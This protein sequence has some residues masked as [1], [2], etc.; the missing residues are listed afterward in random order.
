MNN[1]LDVYMYL[2]VCVLE[3]IISP[4]KSSN[5]EAKN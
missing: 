5:T 4:L 1:K 3:F 2:F